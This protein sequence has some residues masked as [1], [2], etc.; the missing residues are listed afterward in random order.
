M[1]Q[2]GVKVLFDENFSPVLVSI[3][4]KLDSSLRLETVGKKFGDGAKDESWIPQAAIEGY[5]VI[6]FDRKQLT[7][8]VVA[9]A[10]HQCGAR[11][12]FLPDRLSKTKRWDQALWML[13]HFRVMHDRMSEFEAGD[14]WHIS[15][16]GKFRP[17]SQTPTS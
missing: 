13:R 6:T 15:W 16:N 2:S 8:F 12:I 7:D 11:A 14:L 10:L 3:L 17:V 4:R 5:V 1:A 9:P